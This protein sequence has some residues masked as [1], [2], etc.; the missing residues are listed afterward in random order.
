MDNTSQVILRNLD[1]LAQGPVLLLN[2]APDTLAG[3]LGVH[4]QTVRASTASFSVHNF[5]SVNGAESVFEAVPLITN[6]VRTVIMTLPREKDL[7]R[8]W[9]DACSAQLAEAGSLWLVGENR[10]GIKSAGQ[11][12]K[13]NFGQVLKVDSARHCSLLEARQARPRETFELGRYEQ[14]WTATFGGGDI[15][16]ASLPGVFSHGRLDPGTLLLLEVLHKLAPTGRVL[17][18]ASGSGV[19][20]ASV[21]RAGNVDLTLL[22]DSALAIESGNRT[23][24][25]NGIEALSLPSDGL[26]ELTGRFDWILSNPPFHRGIRDDLNVAR[27]FFARAGT[28]LTERGKICVV[29]NQ[30][31]PYIGWMRE[32]FQIIEP[33]AQSGGFNV[34]QVSKPR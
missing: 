7:L 24:A 25:L 32:Y 22:D 21:A 14:R 18:F 34:I 5:L 30:H 15:Q 16:V 4:G 23:L 12:L 13:Q 29:F 11:Y 33:L 2:P 17:D 20:G 6:D 26:T 31:L 9:L 19:I 1:R 27:S 3:R 28:F 10:A 8:M